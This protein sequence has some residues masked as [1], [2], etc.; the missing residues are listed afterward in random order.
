VSKKTK[1]HKYDVSH[2]VRIW[3]S[4]EITAAS[5]DDAL[6]KA[7]EMKC[8]DLVTTDEGVSINDSYVDLIGVTDMTA[9][10][11]VGA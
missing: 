4:T 8:D 3:T 5:Y 1:L 11:K 2:A 10:D 7:R 9:L 6:A